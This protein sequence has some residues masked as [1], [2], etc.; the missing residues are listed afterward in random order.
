MS[1]EDP[2]SPSGPTRGS[3]EA[4]QH[5][6]AMSHMGVAEAYARLAN[7]VE[8]MDSALL[9]QVFAERA[10]FV[11]PDATAFE[12]RPAIAAGFEDL[13]SGTR[14]RGMGLRLDIEV[15]DRV[16]RDD[17]VHDQGSYALYVRI[18]TAELPFKKGRF[19]AV[20][21]RRKGK[22]EYRIDTAS[23]NPLFRTF[24]PT[25]GVN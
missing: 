14:E 5:A 1:I 7:A 4:R 12:G 16:A 19:L 8:R 24:R 23:V 9:A 22:L 18:G 6:T 2:K 15:D 17:V 3:A 10:V 13:F 20:F 25:S 11:S 21:R